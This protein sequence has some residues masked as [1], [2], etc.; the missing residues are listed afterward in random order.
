MLSDLEKIEN[1]M[2]ENDEHLPSISRT[3]YLG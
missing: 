3:T 1:K 2:F